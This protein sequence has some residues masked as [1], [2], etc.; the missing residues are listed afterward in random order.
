M[1][2]H[3][4]GS[5]RRSAQIPLLS[6]VCEALPEVVRG[7]SEPRASRAGLPLLL[8]L[9]LRAFAAAGVPGALLL[10]RLPCILSGATDQLLNAPQVM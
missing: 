5:P 1:Q 4:S 9:V 3:V 6:A 7:G 2:E 10:L 8:D